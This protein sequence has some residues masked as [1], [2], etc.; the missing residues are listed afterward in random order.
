MKKTSFLLILLLVTFHFSN[1]FA[2]A[3]SPEIVSDNTNSEILESVTGTSL[4]EADNATAEIIHS[5][6]T[7][8]DGNQDALAGLLPI[9]AVSPVHSAEISHS[10]ALEHYAVYS[11]PQLRTK[12][13]YMQSYN[14]G[15]RK[16][17][18][19]LKKNIFIITA[20]NAII[21]TGVGTML[22]KSD[23]NNYKIG[24]AGI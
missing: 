13:A 10:L 6:V 14:Q 23:N 24:A 21:A 2:V 4:P 19:S 8:S 16:N 1:A 18:N 9:Q 22:M 5:A 11:E 12:P 3:D 15:A 20:V 7:P 17:R